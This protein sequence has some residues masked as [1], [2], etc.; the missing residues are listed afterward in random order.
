MTEKEII[1][2]LRAAIS[3]VEWNYPSKVKGKAEHE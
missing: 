3:E 2:T 1:D